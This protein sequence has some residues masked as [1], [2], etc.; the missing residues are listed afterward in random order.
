MNMLNATES[1]FKIVNF[2]VGEFYLKKKK[3]AP[4]SRQTDLQISTLTIMVLVKTVLPMGCDACH[5]DCLIESS[6]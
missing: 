2:M 3:K 1:H 5:V 6:N 4:N